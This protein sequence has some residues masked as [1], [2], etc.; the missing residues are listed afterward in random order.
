M[1]KSP[2]GKLI[3]FEGIDGS[4]KSTHLKRV[5][6]FLRQRNLSVVV[7]REPGSTKAAERI[8]EILL[9]RRLDITDL[10]ELLLYEAARAELTWREI[11]PALAQGE[12]VLCDRF[13]DSTTAYQGYGRGIPLPV[14]RR[15]HQIAVGRIKPALTLLFDLDLRASYGRRGKTPDRLEAQSRVFFNRVRRGYLEIAKREPRRI[16]VVKTARPVEIVAAE[17]IHL[18]KEKLRLK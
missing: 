2:R 16:H 12:I 1:T 10:A 7:L 15:L 5:E 17:V 14:V 13:Y 6:S 18:V 3:T 11:E 4:G 9:D 8:R